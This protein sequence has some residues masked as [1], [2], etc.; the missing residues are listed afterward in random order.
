MNLEERY[1]AA[2]ENTYVGRVRTRQA[3]EAGAGPGVNFLDGDA[4]S[5]WTPG[6][7]AAPDEFQKE[8]TRN[9]PGAFLYGG[10]GKEPGVGTSYT[11]SR[12]LSKS[13][14]IAF[15]GVGPSR[16]P[17]GYWKNP[18]FTT[19]NDVRNGNTTLHRYAPEAGASF[20]ESTILSEMSK[21][22]IAG[23]ASGPSPAGLQG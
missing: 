19:V 8:F 6:A 3:A 5:T 10:D 4:R 12:W 7:E 14:N 11:L 13:L 22:R 16:L 21:G 15:G 1:N 23:S 20:A 17:T 18:R 2:S 9:N